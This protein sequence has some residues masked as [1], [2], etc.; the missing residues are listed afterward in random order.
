[1][2]FL[3]VANHDGEE[4]VSGTGYGR[5][6]LT[7]MQAEEATKEAWLFIQSMQERFIEN[8]MGYLDADPTAVMAHYIKDNYKMNKP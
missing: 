2:K 3:R 1:M 5:I 8:G 7:E 6:G 4:G